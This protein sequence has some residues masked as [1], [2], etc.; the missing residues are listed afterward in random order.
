MCSSDLLFQRTVVKRAKTLRLRHHRYP[1]RFGSNRC[2][3]CR[4]TCRH[5][6]TG[7]PL[8]QYDY[9]RAG[10]QC[11][12]PASKQNHHQRRYPQWYETRGEQHLRLLLFLH[13]A[14]RR[15]KKR[16]KNYVRKTKSLTIGKVYCQKGRLKIFRRPFLSSTQSIQRKAPI[17]IVFAIACPA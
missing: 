12:T 14:Y 6:P 5:S 1:A 16:Q 4:T 10:Y 7:Q 11:G 13:N 15:Q 9:Q 3:R 8:R 17:S 2:R